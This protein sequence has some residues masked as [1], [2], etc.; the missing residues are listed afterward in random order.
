MET[1]YKTIF[2]QNGLAMLSDYQFRAVKCLLASPLRL[3]PHMQE[4]YD[5]IQITTQMF[6]RFLGATCV[7][8]L[9]EAIKGDREL[10]GL[11]KS[12]KRQLGEVRKRFA[13]RAAAAPKRKKQVPRVG[14]SASECSSSGPGEAQR[15]AEPPR[16]QEENT[17]AQ[18]QSEPHRSTA[19]G[20]PK[21]PPAAAG[22]QPCAPRNPPS[23]TSAPDPS[24]VASAQAKRRRR[25]QSSALPETSAANLP[26]TPVQNPQKPLS[27]CGQTEGPRSAPQAARTPL[28]AAL[29]H[30]PP[31]APAAATS[32]PSTQSPPVTHHSPAQSSASTR[33]TGSGAPSSSQRS[34]SAQVPR[35]GPH[36]SVQSSSTPQKPHS[37]PPSSSK[38]SSSTQSPLISWEHN[39]YPTTKSWSPLIN[40]EHKLN[41]ATTSWYSFISREHDLGQSTTSRSPIISRKCNFGPVTASGVPIISQENDLCPSTMSWSRLISQKQ[42]LGS[43]TTSWSLLIHRKHDL[44]PGTT[45]WFILVNWDIDLCPGTMSWSHLDSHKHDSSP[46]TASGS[47][48]IT[49]KNDRCPSTMSWSHLISR[50]QDLGSGTT[51]WSVLV[52]WEID[53]CPEEGQQDQRKE[54]QVLDVTEPFRYH[55]DR[56]MFHAIVAIKNQTQNQ[57]VRVKV[58][59][60]S[61]KTNFL[62][63]NILVLSNYIGHGGFVEVYKCTSVEKVGY[64]DVPVWL[65]NMVT[66]NPK[67]SHLRQEAP[68]T[69]VNGV[70]LVSKKVVRHPCVYYEVQDE[71]GTMQVVVYGHLT[72]IPC[73]RGNRIQLICFE[74]GEEQHQLR[75]SIHSF[76]KPPPPQFPSGWETRAPGTR[77]QERMHQFPSGW[78]TQEPSN[79][80]LSLR[81][82]EMQYKKIFLKKGLE[83]LSDYQFQAVKCLL[84]IPLRLTPEMQ[85]DYDRI[86]ITNRIFD[87]FSGAECVNQLIKAI[88]GDR[89]LEDLA[90]SL[91]QQLR[92]V[93][94]RTSAQVPRPGPSSSAGSTTSAQVPRPGSP[95]SARSATSAQ[96]ARPQAPP[97]AKPCNHILQETPILAKVLQVSKLFVIKARS[98]EERRLFHSTVATTTKFFPVKVY[99][100][101]LKDRFA[102]KKVLC[103]S[104]YIRAKGFLEVTGESSVTEVKQEVRVPGTV[105]EKAKKS[106]QIRTLHTLASGTVLS[107]LFTLSKISNEKTKTVYEIEDKTGTMDVM[108]RGRYRNLPCHEGDKL[109]LFGVRL[110]IHNQ[111]RALYSEEDS[112]IQVMKRRRSRSS[113]F[114]E[115]SAANLTPTPVQTPQESLSS[116]GQTEGPCPAPQAASLHPLSSSPA[117]S[118]PSTQLSPTTHHSPAQSSASAR[119]PCPGPHS[120]DQSSSSTQSASRLV[121]TFPEEGQQY[122]CKEMVVLDVTESFRYRE[123]RTMFH[124]IVAIKN[125]AQNLIVRV[126]I[127]HEG[128]KTKF[129]LGNILVLSHYFGRWGFVEVYKYTSVEKV[130]YEEVPEWLINMV[131]ETPKISHL[132]QEAP[133]TV[134]NGVFL[135]SKKVVRYPCVYYEVQDETGTM[136]VVVYGHLT[137]IPCERGN[138]I[139]LICFERGEDQDEIRSL[140]HS[141][142]KVV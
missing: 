27:I 22:A 129:V 66:E 80:V 48:I 73:E 83:K 97:K 102:C 95:S 92:K 112:F 79:R 52:N 98:G 141:F 5:R 109:R 135:V 117:I 133:N 3:T 82:M 70:F 142:L 35:T 4:D 119:R 121:D 124:A 33:Q 45:S 55:E 136:Q 53:L 42:D 114:P 100:P 61:F 68:N 99:N 90:K 34:S 1:Q 101:Q 10:E 94:R 139:Q 64:E 137:A 44:C 39:L 19:Y 13:E 12:L 2:L 130:G 36:S 62:P 67:I 25:S 9:I 140:M 24:S 72:G 116:S 54:M 87:Q 74:R 11:V 110:K 103:I 17:W 113:A 16:A 38:R 43:G 30:L 123:D 46:G 120:S 126:K 15:A 125:Q 75:S 131:T 49:Q 77:T 138:R 65:I 23:P 57:I 106:P 132:R 81:H 50:K 105:L 111:K 14:P 51:S 69:I 108:C 89:E 63:L 8:Q 29:L 91:K 47:P 59:H 41:P 128:F 134:V 122:Q 20:A 6:A 7:M 88:K 28:E 58:F 104:H 31:P 21:D 115:T 18:E 32:S 56:T 96:D 86:Q 84:A 78:E 118:S 71:T 93:R 37:V 60:E 26:P 107:G 76:L 127:F 40:W 85:E